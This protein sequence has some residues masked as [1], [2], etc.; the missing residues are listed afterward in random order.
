MITERQKQL[1]EFIEKFMSEHGMAPTIREIG[2]GIGVKSTGAVYDIL[3]RLEAKGYLQ[4]PKGTKRSI[5]LLKS[6]FFGIPI[7]GNIPAGDPI[8][9]Y[10]DIEEIVPLD[11]RYFGG[12]KLYGLR[13]VG[14]SMI[15]AGICE[16]D[17]AIIRP[18]TFAPDGKIV[19][20][21]LDEIEP[22]V[23]LKYL[24]KK[25]GGF[26]LVPANP[27]YEERFFTA[28][29]VARSKIRVIGTMVGL[30]RKYIP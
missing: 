10:E 19:A 5:K 23:T 24:Y 4:I 8:L 13:V 2:E 22:E 28:E 29:D 18:E 20:A 12:E 14:D 7:I 16:G 9:P 21:L 25:N 26:S 17:I 1:L 27:N 11:P 30:I 3:K 6:H 15:E